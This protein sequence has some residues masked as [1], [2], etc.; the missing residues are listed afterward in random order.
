[1]TTPILK[2]TSRFGF[3]DDARSRQRGVEPE[4]P[5][6]ARFGARTLAFIACEHGEGAAVYDISNENQPRFTQWLP[7]GLAP[8][9]VLAL[10][11][12]GLFVTAN[13]GDA[14]LSI[15]QVAT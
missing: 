14:T 2:P 11:R 10:P 1:L 12:R 9:G 7:S 15:F 8:E 13:E 4:T 5:T 6:V 3:Y